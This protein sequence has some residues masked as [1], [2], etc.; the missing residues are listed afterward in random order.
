MKDQEK[1]PEFWE[2]KPLGQ[3]A[4][5]I[6]KGATPTTYGY[7]FYESGI[8]FIKIENVNDGFVD[9]KTIKDYISFE[10][11]EFQK[12]SQLEENDLLF[13]IAG[14]IGET[15]IIRKEY[16]PANTNQAFAIIRGAQSQIIPEFLAFQLN[17]FVQRI[18]YKARGGAMNNISIGDLNGIP[19]IIPPLKDQHPIV[20]K[21]NKLFSELDAARW[22][23]ETVKKQID[24]YKQ[25]VFK[26][27]FEGG[28]SKN[29]IAEYENCS[30]WK[31]TKIADVGEIVSGGTPSTK[32]PEYWDGDIPWITP[33]DLSGYSNKYID[34]GR[35]S[36][37]SKGLS[38][39]S[40]RIIPSGSVLLSSR[41]PIGYVAIAKNELCTNQGFKSIIPSSRVTSE[42]LYYFLKAH[43][44][45]IIERASGTTFK[46]VSLRTISSLEIIIPPIKQQKIIVAEI[47]HR[48][49]FCDK[50][51]ETIFDNI[52]RSEILKQS[53]LKQAFEGK[54]VKPQTNQQINCK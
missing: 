2:K 40:A 8:I 49:S 43:T 46:E 20:E 13:S 10:A 25:A 45:K 39:S 47:E 16:L 1:L 17:A 9:V 22:Q 27:A 28:L 4:V 14:T 24:L 31:I 48:F 18:K 35:R 41:A 50:M 29:K 5:R 37:T 12:R 26:S 44:Q 19:I 38:K 52:Q 51:E 30:A 21:I 11:H 36:I 6:T 3:V 54:L 53:I 42:Y 32:E 23:L 33:A 34:K 7:K 15:C